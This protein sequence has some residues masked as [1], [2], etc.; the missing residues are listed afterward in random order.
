MPRI[1]VVDAIQSSRGRGVALALATKGMLRKGPHSETKR[2]GAPTFGFERKL[3]APPLG[4]TLFDDDLCAAIDWP[5][6]VG[7]VGAGGVP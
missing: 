4:L 7:V 3:T 2:E 5:S 6:A 1:G